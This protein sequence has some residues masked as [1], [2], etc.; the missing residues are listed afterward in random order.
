[1]WLVRRAID[2]FWLTALEVSKELRQSR[3]RFAD[4]NVVSLWKILGCRDVWST[5][6]DSFA[7]RLTS[8][9]HSQQTVF[10]DQHGSH[11]NHVGPFDI[12][13]SQF[14][15]LHVDETSFPGCGQ[16]C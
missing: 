3:F 5:D 11:K 10:L 4:E 2:C 1:R 14:P 15:D 7:E 13:A 9:N 6:H 8:L 16:Q 12:G